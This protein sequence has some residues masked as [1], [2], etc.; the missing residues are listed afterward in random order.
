MRESLLKWMGGKHALA[1]YILGKI[2]P[3]K[4]FVDVFAGGLHITLNKEN[5]EE[6]IVNDIN[7][8][9]VDVYRC[10]W[11]STSKAKLYELLDTGIYSERAFNEYKKIYDEPETF[12]KKPIHKRAF[13]YI[14]LNRTSFNGKGL[15]FAKRTDGTVL[16]KLHPIINMMHRKFQAGSYVFSEADFEEIIEKY[17]SEYTFFYLDPPY[18]VT[19]TSKG[20][21]YY[22]I[23]MKEK[24]H[25]RLRDALIKKCVLGKWLLSYDDVPQIRKLYDNFCI[26]L[27]PKKCQTSGNA[28]AGQKEQEAVYKQELLIANYDIKDVNTLFENVEEEQPA[29]IQKKYVDEF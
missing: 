13:M 25:K 8:N 28:I 3:H 19:S 11:N 18:Y 1:P 6:N 4:R 15:H 5:A 7:G 22:E 16:Y 24:D 12:K 10:I 27:T 17:D 23:V 26:I 29:P 21:D 20:A 2:K 14:Y 9:L